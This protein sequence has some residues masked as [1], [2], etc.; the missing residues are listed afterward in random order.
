[1]NKLIVPLI[2]TVIGLNLSSCDPEKT[3]HLNGYTQTIKNDSDQEITWLYHRLAD[4]EEKIVVIDTL[5]LPPHTKS[6]RV[7]EGY[8]GYGYGVIEGLGNEVILKDNLFNYNIT[9]YSS[10][11]PKIQLYVGNQFVKEW[12]GTVGYMGDSI[13]SPLNYD[14][15]EVVKYDKVV[16]GEG[17]IFIHGELVFTISNEDLN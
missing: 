13:N 10:E 17:W 6:P 14:S 4:K 9:S 3:F 2:V 12:K 7:F 15:W 1:M 16:K 8:H 11:A 5:T